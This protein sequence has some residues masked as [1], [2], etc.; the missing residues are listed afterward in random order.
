M[1]KILS[2]VVM[3]AAFAIAACGGSDNNNGGG[4]GSGNT[5]PGAPTITSVTA[6]NAQVLVTF[7]APAS[8]GGAAITNYTATCTGLA[9]SGSAS[10]ATSPITVTG[11]INGVAYTC[12]V[13]A[14]NSVGNSPASAA[15]TAVTPTLPNPSLTTVTPVVTWCVGACAGKFIYLTGA[16]FA[17]GDQV[18]IV[19][20]SDLQQGVF[21]S[22]TEVLLSIMIDSYHEGSGWRQPTICKPDG[23]GCSNTIPFGLYGPNACGVTPSGEKLC[24]NAGET[25]IDGTG[26]TGIGTGYVDKFKP[27]TGAPD[28]ECYFG[29]GSV[30]IAVDDVTGW[31]SSGIDPIDPA[32]C[33]RPTNAPILTGTGGDIGLR[34]AIKIKNGLSC[35]LGTTGLMCVSWLGGSG[36]TNPIM[37]SNFGNNNQSLAMGVTSNKTY[38]YAFDADG[39]ALYKVDVTDGTTITLSWPVT[40]VTTGT[41]LEPHGT[42]IVLFDS[43]N[44]GMLVSYSDNLAVVFDETTL[45]TVATISLPGIP[46]SV[47]AKGNIAIVGNADQANSG[48]NFTV[49]D[50][51]KG[52]ASL[53]PSEEAAFLPTGLIPAVT[54]DGTG[55]DFYACPQD[56]IN[57]CSSFTLPK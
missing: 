47:V 21:E 54:A 50:P 44:L 15:S 18:R 48:G 39:Q 17:L 55:V 3:S 24:L 9:S 46:V 12:T 13:T 45:K 19:P 33:A 37:V 14:T 43:L 57:P 2:L 27:I 7:S 28:G 42:E 34:M 22:S 35:S 52:T 25:E 51:V 36:A 5:V 1:K 26:T 16:N 38:A 11:L 40:G 31:F 23:T 29:A 53:I 8:N 6:G 4:G 49:V 32:T 20:D 41:V 10:G 56:S 30:A